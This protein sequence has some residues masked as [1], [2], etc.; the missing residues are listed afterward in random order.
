MIRLLIKSNA[1]NI[2]RDQRVKVRGHAPDRK[3]NRSDLTPTYSSVGGLCRTRDVR[4]SGMGGNAGSGISRGN[5]SG[6]GNSPAPLILKEL[7]QTRDFNER[8]HDRLT[9]GKI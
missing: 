3:A 7:S 8:M 9:N 6:F 5:G 1:T 4:T 2:Q